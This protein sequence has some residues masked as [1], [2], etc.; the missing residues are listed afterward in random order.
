MMQKGRE[1]GVGSRESGLH[2]ERLA[3]PR[4]PDVTPGG[5]NGREP[6]HASGAVPDSRLP[7]PG[8][9]LILVGLPGVGKSTVGAGVAER[10]GRSFLDFDVEIE[11]REGQSVAEIFAERGEGAFRELERALTEEVRTAPSMVLAPGGGWVARET[12]VALLRPP[13]RIIFLDASPETVLRRLGEDRFRRPLLSGA[14]PLGALHRL[15]AHRGP[16]Y[17]SADHVI[18]AE[19]TD[20]QELI[21]IVAEL[22]P[23]DRGG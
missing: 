18:D 16:A 7:T 6:G 4:T 8:S 12:N 23:W 3:P 14:D 22:A 20:F 15:L 17:R 21:R 1:S 5:I 9:H 19:V 11:R 2:P 13:G 10:L